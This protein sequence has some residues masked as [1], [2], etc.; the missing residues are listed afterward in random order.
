M[1]TQLRPIG[2]ILRCQGV[3]NET[4]IGPAVLQQRTRKIQTQRGL[5]ASSILS[6]RRFKLSSPAESSCRF[7]PEYLSR[8]QADHLMR[9]TAFSTSTRRRGP[10]KDEAKSTDE[11]K[12]DAQGGTPSGGK[13]G[14]IETTLSPCSLDKCSCFLLVLF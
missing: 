12:E 14:E 8:W 7:P 9:K 10:E 1:K 13:P 2:L 5:F 3:R 6:M 4:A 11:V